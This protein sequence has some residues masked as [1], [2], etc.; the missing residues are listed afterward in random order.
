[1][2][3]QKIGAGYGGFP[4]RLQR[5]REQRK[6]SRRVLS[7]LCGLSKSAISRYE[8]GEQEPTAGVLLMLADY[9]GV[10]TDYLLGR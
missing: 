10:P 7:E 2:N 8:R 6:I 5:L 4:Q 3:S 9:F 1:M